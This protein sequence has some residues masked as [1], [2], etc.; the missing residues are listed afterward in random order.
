MNI[1][2]LVTMIQNVS[3]SLEA[4]QHFI[5]G[6]AYI[7]GLIFILIAFLKFKSLGEKMGASGG[8]GE[9]MFVPV[10]YLVVGAALL[11][12]PSALQVMSNTAFGTTNILEYRRYDTNTLFGALSIIVRTA[13]LIWFVRGCV[14][15]AHASEPGVQH[16]PKGL[17]FLIAGILAVN[18]EMTV[19]YFNWIV[20]QVNLYFGK[21]GK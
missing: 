4:V 5:G 8:S 14:L 6:L 3:R 16:G 18:F 15:L 7:I 12:L 1:P 10:A 11:F 19:S 21:S 9:K 17:T 2:D 13:G 20:D